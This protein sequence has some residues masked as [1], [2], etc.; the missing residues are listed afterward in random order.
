[1]STC[2]I[3]DSFDVIGLHSSVELLANLHPLVANYPVFFAPAIDHYVVTRFSDIEAICLDPTTFSSSSAQVPIASL[4]PEARAVLS[5]WDNSSRPSILSL[6]PPAHALLR[7]PLA[8]A[9]TPERVMS[10]ETSIRD[11]AK[12]LLAQIVTLPRF[13]LVSALAFPLPA[14][15]VFSF[16]GIPEADWPLLLQWCSHRALLTWGQPSAEEQVVCA[17]SIDAYRSYLND[18]VAN[19]IENREGNFTEALLALRRE[20]SPELSNADISAILYSLTFAGHRT[21]SN[22][23]SNS[24]YQFL[25]RDGL[26]SAF[27]QDASTIERIVREVLRYDPPV[28]SLQRIAT[29]ETYI[30]GFRVPEGSKILL[31]IAASCCD[32]KIY[33][34]PLKWNH[35]RVGRTRHLGFGRGIHYC[36]GASLGKLETQVAIEELARLFPALIIDA[37]YVV[38]YDADLSFR[39]VREL[40]VTH[41]GRAQSRLST[42]LG[43]GS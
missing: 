37:N 43:E 28:L 16:V 23:I 14:S 24:I 25:S 20:N 4:V 3:V 29:T 30:D 18:F 33:P 11:C 2:P 34:D 35:N 7:A 6:D 8:R 15:T 5:K 1:M 42:D 27:G 17:V 13:D 39:G 22:L 10:L 26:W 9:F 38:S 31:W 32:K 40:W 21:T 36:I 41:M 12:R 19:T